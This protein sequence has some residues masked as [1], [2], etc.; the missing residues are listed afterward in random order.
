MNNGRNGSNSNSVSS[1]AESNRSFSGGSVRSSGSM[2]YGGASSSSAPDSNKSILERHRT[3]EGSDN[4]VRKLADAFIK[5][6]ISSSGMA[7]IVR[8]QQQP[9]IKNAQAIETALGK[10]AIHVS[11]VVNLYLIKL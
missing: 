11:F 10:N 5:K 2:L 9:R 1:K 4:N 6:L 3:N 7:S 8:Q